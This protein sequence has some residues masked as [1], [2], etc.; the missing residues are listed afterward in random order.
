MI[1][2]RDYHH[3]GAIKQV[4]RPP[5]SD[6]LDS[7][8]LVATRSSKKMHLRSRALFYNFKPQALE[9]GTPKKQCAV[10]SQIG[11]VVLRKKGGLGF[12]SDT[13]SDVDNDKFT[14]LMQ[15]K[16]SENDQSLPQHHSFQAQCESLQ[17]QRDQRFVKF[18]GLLSLPGR[19]VNRN[20][21]WK[22]QSKKKFV[23]K[24]GPRISDAASLE[25]TLD[26]AF[27]LSQSQSASTNASVI[28]IK[29]SFLGFQNPSPPVLTPESLL[30]PSI[31]QSLQQRQDCKQTLNAYQADLVP[32]RQIGFP[33][34]SQL[35]NHNKGVS[36]AATHSG[37]L[38][39]S[40]FKPM[41]ANSPP[42][43][44]QIDIA[45]I[46]FKSLKDQ[47]KKEAFICVKE[48]D[49]PLRL[50]QLEEEQKKAHDNDY[51]SDDE[52]VKH[53]KGTLK[54][55]L[56]SAFK[57]FVKKDPLSFVSNLQREVNIQEFQKP[58]AQNK[59][60]YKSPD[61][62]PGLLPVLSTPRPQ[63][64]LVSF[65]SPSR[66]SKTLAKEQIISQ[67]QLGFIYSPM[68]KEPYKG[69]KTMRSC[70]PRTELKQSDSYYRQLS[71]DR[72]A[73]FATNDQQRTLRNRIV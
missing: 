4:R 16:G 18:G 26:S 46:K 13:M 57:R 73:P 42:R 5:L 40:P 33:P 34:Q 37:A 9:K 17:K 53:N 3:Q 22:Q 36:Q 64:K 11:K 41:F 27:S 30:L 24:F 71:K 63:E 47:R 58:S 67:S 29:P 20:G 70:F 48:Q 68:M 38:P 15:Q 23:K 59:E 69:G 12:T 62:G 19:R 7:A 50:R 44:S 8:G 31:P 66:E 61:P 65:H 1:I 2:N 6:Q 35:I 56:L 32:K 72:V 43:P 45:Q 55:E 10:R 51:P 25:W 28:H 14:P 21:I 49:M 39:S 60:A 52:Q 54:V